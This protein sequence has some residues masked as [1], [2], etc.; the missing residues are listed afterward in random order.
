MCTCLFHNQ[1]QSIWILLCCCEKGFLEKDLSIGNFGKIFGNVV[2]E[3]RNSVH[4]IS[5]EQ[6]RN[7]SVSTETS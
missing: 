7:F 1:M 6:T 4:Y 5:S 2:F 3:K